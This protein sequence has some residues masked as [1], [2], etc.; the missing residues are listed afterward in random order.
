MLEVLSFLNSK[1]R[2]EHGNIVTIDSMWK[3]AGLDS[4]GTT[5]VL[6]DMDNEYGCFPKEWFT[7]VDWEALKVSD[8][9]DKVQNESTKL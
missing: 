9:L 3:D 7:T 6:A 5:M 1:I 8:I 4:F 2:D